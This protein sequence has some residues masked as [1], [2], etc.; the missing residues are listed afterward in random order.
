[1]QSQRSIQVL[2]SSGHF[3]L[4]DSLQIVLLRCSLRDADGVSP[5]SPPVATDIRSRGE[6]ANIPCGSGLPDHGLRRPQHDALLCK[7]RRRPKGGVMR[8][9]PI[10]SMWCHVVATLC[11]RKAAMGRC[12]CTVEAPTERPTW[13]SLVA[14]MAQR[15]AVRHGRSLYP[16][17]GCSCGCLPYYPLWLWSDVCT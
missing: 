2:C 14:K 3:Q 15:R 1:M 8:E 11:S 17:P 4:L 13:C 7:A 16:Q 6:R 5:L 12:D 10:A 9:R